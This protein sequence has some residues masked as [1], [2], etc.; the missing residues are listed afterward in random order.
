[1]L[2][3]NISQPLSSIRPITCLIYNNNNN[4]NNN[5]NQGKSTEKS[6]H[7]AGSKSIQIKIKFADYFIDHSLTT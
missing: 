5:F 2:Y 1:M 4:N 7:K 3:Y 6:A